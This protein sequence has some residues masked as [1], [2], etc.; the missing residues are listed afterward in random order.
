[1]DVW[2]YSM[3]LF[4]SFCQHHFTLL[5]SSDPG[6]CI[7]SCE[8]S[9]TLPV[10]TKKVPGE[11]PLQLGGLDWWSEIGMPSTFTLSY[12]WMLAILRT[13]SKSTTL[14]VFF[15]WL[16]GLYTLIW[17]QS[18]PELQ[19][20]WRHMGGQ[21]SRSLAGNVVSTCNLHW[22]SYLDTFFCSEFGETSVDGHCIALGF[23]I[24]DCRSWG[25]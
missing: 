16:G 15:S 18:W 25:S 19:S 3:Y 23:S 11:T 14:N 12:C 2:T 6:F 22:D 9:V 21:P 7:W 17:L 8:V 24:F 13:C 20:K 1:M 4:F 5:T 10:D